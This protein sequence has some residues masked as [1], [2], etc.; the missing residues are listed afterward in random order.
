MSGGGLG[1]SV[2][3]KCCFTANYEFLGGLG[4]NYSRSFAFHSM[5]PSHLPQIKGSNPISVTLYSRLFFLCC[6]WTTQVL[7]SRPRAASWHCGGRLPDCRPHDEAHGRFVCFSLCA[8]E[9]SRARQE[10]GAEVFP[11]RAPEWEK[12]LPLIPDS[13]SLGSLEQNCFF[14][15]GKYIRLSGL[16]V[17]W[18]MLKWS[19]IFGVCGL[20][21][22]WWI[23]LY[24][25]ILLSMIHWILPLKKEAR[26]LFQV[27][28]NLF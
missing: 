18:K 12:L 25:M 26:K 9:A 5:P 4:V 13:G 24:F 11:G 6:V 23:F 20:G 22:S 10:T 21:L 19:L 16:T 2:W 3:Q 1:A 28:L 27:F 15:G 7:E 8:G 17:N 14:W